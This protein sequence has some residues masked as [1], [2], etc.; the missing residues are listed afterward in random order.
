MLFAVPL[1]DVRRSAAEEGASSNTG[2]ETGAGGGGATGDFRRLLALMLKVATPLLLAF[3]A[4]LPAASRFACCSRLM[5]SRAGKHQGLS[6][7]LLLR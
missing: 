7:Q 6:L 5:V 1:E 3:P 2:A 4:G